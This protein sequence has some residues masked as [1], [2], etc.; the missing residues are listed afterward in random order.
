M[1]HLDYARD[2]ADGNAYYCKTQNNPYAA[3]VFMRLWDEVGAQID[4][5][6]FIRFNRAINLKWRRRMVTEQLEKYHARIMAR[7]IDPSAEEYLDA[8]TEIHEMAAREPA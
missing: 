7:E 3:A 6:P 5:P 1:N 2:L 8:L 4:S